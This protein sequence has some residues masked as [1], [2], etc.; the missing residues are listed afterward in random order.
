MFG[1]QNKSV[2]R[3]Q[4]A[5]IQAIGQAGFWLALLATILIYPKLFA[6]AGWLA[7]RVFGNDFYGDALT[8]IQYALSILVAMI[9]LSLARATTASTAVMLA[10]AAVSRLPVF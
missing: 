7:D 2:S 9:V 3:Q 5:F 10:L 1:R 6:F 8:F 4:S